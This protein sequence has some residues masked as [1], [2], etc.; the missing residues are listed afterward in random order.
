MFALVHIT[1]LLT[2][3]L[4]ASPVKKEKKI[5]RPN[6]KNLKPLANQ[7]GKNKMAKSIYE[8]ITEKII[9]KLEKGIVLYPFMGN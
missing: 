1:A 7:R 2:G 8:I 3:N 4:L 9:E 5:I 6:I